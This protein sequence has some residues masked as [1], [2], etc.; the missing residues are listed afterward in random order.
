MFRKIINNFVQNGSKKESE[1]SEESCS[2]KENS[3]AQKKIKFFR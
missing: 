1:E 2:E 3:E